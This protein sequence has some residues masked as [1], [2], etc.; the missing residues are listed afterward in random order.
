V[1]A[2]W[3]YPRI[4]IPVQNRVINYSTEGSGFQKID[5][6]GE[7]AKEIVLLTMTCCFLAKE[8]ML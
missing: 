8:G 7:D 3:P 6:I 2:Q 5:E 1:G 4:V